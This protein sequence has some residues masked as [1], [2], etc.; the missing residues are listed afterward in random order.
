MTK[1]EK[2]ELFNELLA[3]LSK[4]SVSVEDLPE[5]N[6]LDDVN[7]FPAYKKD[8]KE[9][10]TIPS[11]A[12][13]E[14]SN[15]ADAAAQSALS[16]AQSC[17]IAGANANSAVV[18]V[19]QT[20]N[21]LPGQV[22]TLVNNSTSAQSNVNSRIINFYTSRPSSN[23]LE[24]EMTVSE[25]DYRTFEQLLEEEYD[26]AD[27]YDHRPI[28]FTVLQ[29]NGVP[30][31][32]KIVYDNN[33]RDSQNY[34]DYDLSGLHERIDTLDSRVPY[35]AGIIELDLVSQGETTSKQET[36]LPSNKNYFKF[37][38]I[39]EQRDNRTVLCTIVPS[40]TQVGSPYTGFRFLCSLHKDGY[41][42]SI[43][44]GKY[45]DVGEDAINIY[46]LCIKCYK[47][48]LGV[49]D[50]MSILKYPIKQVTIRLTEGEGDGHCTELQ[51]IKATEIVEKMI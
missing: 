43:L 32:R 45:I 33:L 34:I 8:S 22:E 9:L 15:K 49:G 44:T 29:N 28:I 7:S 27:G 47:P 37:I 10:V 41:D 20:L 23:A 25:N 12:L 35:D 42:W 14:A 50:R 4:S 39:L 6:S 18:R 38:E 5:A 13:K 3:F 30:K 19:N 31:Y 36:L 24:L 1:Q 17:T 21:S 51:E 16:A 48:N 40:K 26:Y 46:Y 2:D 11:S